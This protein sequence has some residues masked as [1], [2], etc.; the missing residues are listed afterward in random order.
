MS[1]ASFS[2]CALQRHLTLLECRLLEHFKIFT[3][4]YRISELRSRDD[5]IKAIIRNVDYTLCVSYRK[6]VG[7]Q[8]TLLYISETAIRESSC[9]KP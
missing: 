1:G 7:R 3:A 8:L 9:R 5:L 4:F 6:R 2:F